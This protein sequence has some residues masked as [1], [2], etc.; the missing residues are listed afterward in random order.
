[1]CYLTLCLENSSENFVKNIINR[2]TAE[3]ISPT[4]FCGCTET[5]YFLKT[6]SGYTTLVR[7]RT[8][9]NGLPLSFIVTVPMSAY[10]LQG[11][12]TSLF[13]QLLLR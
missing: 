7:G 12:S 9:L 2:R 3:D 5:N 11:S 8:V 10:L 6:D 1:M 4:E 13:F